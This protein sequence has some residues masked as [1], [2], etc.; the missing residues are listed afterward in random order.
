MPNN[1]SDAARESQRKFSAV[2]E[3]SGNLSKAFQPDFF[4]PQQPI[5]PLKLL[6]GRFI[7]LLF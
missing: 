3:S 1:I 2:P 5:M 6:K 4:S 7:T